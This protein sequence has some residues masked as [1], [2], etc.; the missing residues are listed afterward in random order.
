[1]HWTEA[2]RRLQLLKQD[3]PKI[4]GNEMVNFALDN[5]RAESWE[6]APWQKR[7]PGAPRD[8]GRRLLVD[9]G[10]GRR[11][12]KVKSATMYRVLLTAVDYMQA[13]NE[14]ARIQGKYRVRA[15]VRRHRRGSYQVRSHTRNVNFKLPERRFTGKS[16]KQ[17]RRIESVIQKRILKALI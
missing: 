5:I 6:G 4:V 8:R 12:I 1:M 13:H 17:T 7:K 9:K 16:R 11:S 10:H 3:L 2:I 15:H 14:G